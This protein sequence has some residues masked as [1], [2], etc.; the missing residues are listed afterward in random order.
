MISHGSEINK[1]KKDKKIKKEKKLTKRTSSRNKP[2]SFS[3]LNLQ[4][5]MGIKGP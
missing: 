5:D 3:I 4:P 2:Q 1:M